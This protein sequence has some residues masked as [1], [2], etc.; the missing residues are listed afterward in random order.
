MTEHKYTFENNLTEELINSKNIDEW[1]SAF[2]WLDKNGVEYNLCIDN[3][4]GEHIN[5]SAIYKTELIYN[6]RYPDGMVETDYD[7]S[8]HYEIN[9]L[10]KDWEKKLEEAMLKTALHFFKEKEN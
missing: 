2:L 6:E 9:P 7:Q 8:E 4:T 3:T 1:G 10:D 5:C